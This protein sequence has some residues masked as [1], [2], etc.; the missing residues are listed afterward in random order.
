MIQVHRMNRNGLTVCSYRNDMSVWS[1]P[2][3]AGFFKY[4]RSCMKA[5]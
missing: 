3:Y 1:Y 4:C 5:E 2:P